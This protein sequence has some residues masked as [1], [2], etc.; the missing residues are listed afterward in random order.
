MAVKKGMESLTILGVANGGIS[1]KVLT[2]PLS[3]WLPFSDLS[4]S[5]L[6]SQGCA[7]LPSQ[8]PQAL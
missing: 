4:S 6:Y 5:N 1:L 3:V 2:H 8:Q 7:V